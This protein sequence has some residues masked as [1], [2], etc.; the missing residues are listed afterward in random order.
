M[1]AWVEL[2]CGWFQIRMQSGEWGPPYDRSPGATYRSMTFRKK[3]RKD[4]GYARP[5][6]LSFGGPSNSANKPEATP[7]RPHRAACILHLANL[8]IRLGRKLDYDPDKEM[9][10]NDDEANRF[11]NPNGAS[12][13]SLN[14][15]TFL[16]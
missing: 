10:V 14:L 4:Q 5:R 12:L 2:K 16:Q 3:T 11:L 9:F 8:A 1:W 13:A 7:K 15:I 6:A